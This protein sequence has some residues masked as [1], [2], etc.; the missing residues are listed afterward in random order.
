M[1][2]QVS[3][4]TEEQEV[5]VAVARDQRWLGVGVGLFVLIVGAVGGVFAFHAKSPSSNNQIPNNKAEIIAEIPK[6]MQK[7]IA[8]IKPVFAVWNGSGVAGV[9]GKMAEK[10]KSAGYD[11]VET[12]N[13]PKEQ[14]GTTVEIAKELESQK[15]KILELVG[16]GAEPARIILAGDLEYSVKVIIGK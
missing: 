10:L 16:E 9:A 13:A 1:P 4:I 11:V 12:K 7:P 3:E 15:D 2:S 14:I 6:E 8:E 5:K